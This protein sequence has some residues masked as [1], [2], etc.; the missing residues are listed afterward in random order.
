MLREEAQ[1]LGRAFHAL[2]PEQ[3]AVIQRSQI[4]GASQAEI[5]REMGRTS[6]AV[7]KLVARALARLS[8]VLEQ[9]EAADRDEEDQSRPIERTG[10]TPVA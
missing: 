2:T 7:R 4:D 6:E 1:R 10:R 8:A 5:A 3:R 9:S